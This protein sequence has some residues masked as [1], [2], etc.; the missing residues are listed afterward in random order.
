MLSIGLWRWYINITITILDI[1]HRPVFYLKH[2]VS[3]TGFYF[4]LQAETSQMGPI[5]RAS[6]CLLLVVLL[7][8]GDRVYLCL[9]RPSEYVPPEEG[10]IIQSLK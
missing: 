10:D 3:K 9:L 4:R 7:V 5:D 1:I 2:D 6:L 8:S